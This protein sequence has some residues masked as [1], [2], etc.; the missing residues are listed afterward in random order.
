MRWLGESSREQ[1]ISAIDI[2]LCLADLYYL[3]KLALALASPK[4]AE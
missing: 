3:E 4:L 1:I 2:P